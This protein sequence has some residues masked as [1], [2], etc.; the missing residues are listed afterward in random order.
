MAIVDGSGCP[1]SI[2][3]KPASEAEHEHVVDSLDVIESELPENLVGDAAYDDISTQLSVAIEYGVNFRA[4]LRKLHRQQIY[5]AEA[6][7][8]LTQGRWKIERFFA[9]LKKFRRLNMKWEYYSENFLVFVKLGASLILF[10]M[11]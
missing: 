10:S 5:D 3:I 1:V 8:R 4:P 9:H 2:D 6:N 7:K 11:F